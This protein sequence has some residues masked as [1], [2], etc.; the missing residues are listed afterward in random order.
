MILHVGDVDDLRQLARDEPHEVR[1]RV[2]LAKEI[3]LDVGRRVVAGVVGVAI[4]VLCRGDL[5]A[6]GEAR[7]VVHFVELTLK[8]FVDEDLRQR[9]ADARQLPNGL[10]DNLVRGDAVGIPAAVHFD[11]DDVG[12]VEEPAPRVRRA[13]RAGQRLHARRH[14][15]AHDRVVGGAGRD[16]DA[17]VGLY[18]DDAARK[19]P[20]HPGDFRCRITRHDFQTRKIR[21]A[22]RLAGG[23][24]RGLTV[25]RCRRSSC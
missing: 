8:T 19:R 15:L 11:A 16:V 25:G 17:L 4:G 18:G 20:R 22:G 3:R 7:R 1:A 2:F 13:L 12:W 24:C 10:A 6:F 5:Q 21:A 9:Y 14:H 23:R